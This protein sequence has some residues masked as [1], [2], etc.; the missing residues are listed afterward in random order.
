MPRRPSPDQPDLFSLPPPRP[1]PVEVAPPEPP[2]FDIL[3]DPEGF[4]S[5]LD[6]ADVRR[7]LDAVAEEA[8]RRRLLPP[9]PRAVGAPAPSS[10]PPGKEAALRAAL[11]SGLS[12]RMAAR[13]LGVPEATAKALAKRR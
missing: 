1:A 12:P 11:A 9:E 6:D 4:L 5:G 13:T 2:P 3:A 7:L 8:R 10:L